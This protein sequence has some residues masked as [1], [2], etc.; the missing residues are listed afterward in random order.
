MKI[1]VDLEE[2]VFTRLYDNDELSD[3]DRTA[4]EAA[5]R[6]GTVLPEKNTVIEIECQSKKQKT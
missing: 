6:K 2:N 1:M 3:K 5:I 4:I